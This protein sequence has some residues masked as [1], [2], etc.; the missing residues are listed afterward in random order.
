MDAFKR[1]ALPEEIA[2]AALGMASADFGFQ[3]GSTHLVDG[4]QLAGM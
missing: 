2:T 1:M 4:G 3:T